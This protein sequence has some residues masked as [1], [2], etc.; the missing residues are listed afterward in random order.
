MLEDALA[1]FESKVE[2]VEVGVA[3][4]EFVDDAKRLQVVLK[5]AEGS[6]AGI[7]GI[8]TGMTEWRMTKIM[9]QA[10]SLRQGLIE[11]QG[12]GDG[13]RYLRNFH[14]VRQTGSIQ[15]AFMIDEHL[16][17]V[18]QSAESVGMD[19][20]IAIALVFAAELRW[21]LREAPAA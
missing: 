6:H 8:L 14:G 18:D 21:R 9:S 4:L 11:V 15:V 2:P 16:G 20:A 7:Q 1:A 19:D 10:D 12:R 5:T 13:A 17:L 3:V